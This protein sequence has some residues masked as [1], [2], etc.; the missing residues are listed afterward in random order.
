ME[1]K[2]IKKNIMDFVNEREDASFA[3]IQ[4]KFPE[5]F[6]GKGELMIEEKNLWLWGGMQIE[7]VDAIIE[8]QEEK[9]FFFKPVSSWVYAVDGI[10]PNKKIAK[11]VPHNGYKKP[12]WVPV[13]FISNE[14]N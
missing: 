11:N 13:V 1:Y 5:F 12:R 4:F 2:E 10:I 7:V 6:G 3:D 14:K 9:R 8:L